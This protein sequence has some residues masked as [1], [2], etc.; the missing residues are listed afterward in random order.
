[1]KVRAL[2][3]KLLVWYTTLLLVTATTYGIYTYLDLRHAI[4]QRIQNGLKERATQISRTIL[5]DTGDQDPL[6]LAS[7]LNEIYAPAKNGRFI[8]IRR[9][10]GRTLYISPPPFDESFQPEEIPTPPSS[11][12]VITQHLSGKG[13]A[14]FYVVDMPVTV[15]G[16]AYMVEVGAST[17]SID[18][19]LNKLTRTLIYG[20]PVILMISIL[21]GMFLSR[22]ALKPVEEVRAAAEKITY[23]NLNQRLPVERTDDALESLTLT[24]NQM[25]D[26]LDHAY[27]QASRFT[28][29]ASH[30]LRTPLTILRSELEAWQRPSR[31]APT[32][33]QIG[34]LL[35]E[36][37]RLSGIV[38]ALSSIARLDAGEAKMAHDKFDLAQITRACVEQMSLLAEDK[39]IA[40]SLQASEPVAAD[41]DAN[42]MKQVIVN[43][44]DNAIKYTQDGGEIHIQVAARHGRALLRVKD[45]GMGIAAD[46]LPHIFERFYRADKVRT[47]STQG[48]GLGLAIVKSIC[49]AHAGQVYADS[50]EGGGTT[51]T[52][53]LPLA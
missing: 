19:I 27:Q 43:L 40:I 42:R 12:I 4:Y 44:I 8:R 45:N 14:H 33:K 22:R 32:H 17:S 10:D 35:E 9:G 34:S 53:E 41:G 52:V 11:R 25:L 28:A 26:R 48:T 16:V 3:V 37:E 7:L 36:V 49:Q 23:T 20:L 5:P 46:A 24:L 18:S 21:G 51:M 29:D 1:M 15:N 30:E 6:M 39:H 38:E 47:R 2:H 13:D 31:A 50:T